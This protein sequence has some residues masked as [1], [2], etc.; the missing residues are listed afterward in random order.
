MFERWGRFVARRRWAVLMVSLLAFAVSGVEAG[1]SLDGNAT[2]DMVAGAS[3][4]TAKVARKF[5]QFASLFEKKF[6]I[7]S[8]PHR[9]LTAQP[10][11]DATL[12][13][14]Q[15]ATLDSRLAALE[16]GIRTHLVPLLELSRVARTAPGELAARSAELAAHGPHISAV[17]Q[18]FSTEFDETFGIQRTS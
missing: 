15:I 9:L 17:I 5:N 8:V 2:P 13:P 11:K 14:E 16:N 7:T 18:K 4:Q 10:G 3:E 1:I 6:G 12:S